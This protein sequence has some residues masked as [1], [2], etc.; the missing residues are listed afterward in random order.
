MENKYQASLILSPA[1]GQFLKTI[2]NML[3]FF[4]ACQ[5]RLLK[6]IIIKLIPSHEPK[7]ELKQSQGDKKRSTGQYSVCAPG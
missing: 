5:R 4:P 2:S 3:G 6:K 1:P 7:G